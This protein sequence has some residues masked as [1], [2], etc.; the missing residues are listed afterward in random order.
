VASIGLFLP[1]DFHFGH[2]A[3]APFYWTHA[4]LS[5][6]VLL[7]TLTPF[8]QRHPEHLAL[9]FVVGISINMNR[10]FH[11]SPTNPALTADML[12]VLMMGSA[13]YFSWSPWRQLVVCGVACAGFALA[14]ATATIPDQASFG[15]ALAALLVGAGI[16][17]VGGM[18][19]GRYRADLARR[20]VELGDLSARL[21]TL[22]EEERRHISRDLHE[23]VG[24]SLSAL[25][26]YLMAIEK[27]LPAEHRA[28][29]QQTAEARRLAARSAASL[30]ELSQLLRPPVLDDY[31]L[32]P[33]LQTYLR[34]FEARYGVTA[35]LAADGVPERFSSEIETAIYR[36]VQE[37]LTN[38]AHHARARRVRVAL[39]TEPGQVRVEVDDDGV[40]LHPRNGETSN[41]GMGLIGIRERV[42]ALGGSVTLSSRDGARL[43]VRLPIAS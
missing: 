39:V 32:V 31:G 41:R 4:F 43:T 34:E 12:T 33:S 9:A 23:G 25:L 37:A 28:L 26:A 27:D 2:G 13:F 22:Q 6:L 21:M 38:V 11:V 40:G 24:Q 18:V 5:A 20:Q 3:G 35:A 16:A 10:Y 7:G 15:Y 17:T 36:V 1:L 29:R 30:R 14:G 42:Q 8:G 19:L